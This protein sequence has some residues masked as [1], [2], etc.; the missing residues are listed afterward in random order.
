MGNDQSD[1]KKFVIDNDTIETT[2]YWTLHY[3]EV[4]KSDPS[5]LVSVFR[6]E[7]N[8]TG[9]LGKF[10]H[11]IGPLARAIRVCDSANVIRPQFTI[12]LFRQN[13]KIYRHPTILKYIS[14]WQDGCY[15]FLATEQCRPLTVDINKQGNVQICLGLRN[16]LCGL[17]FLV[18][19]VR[20][21]SSLS[22]E[23]KLLIVYNS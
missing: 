5:I 20:H 8:V 12:S 15:E 14:S 21:A 19:Q 13:S 9:Q 2:E 3:A 18:E 22:N 6:S 1:L 23:I 11:N 4:P 10:W 17:I 16:V 7:P